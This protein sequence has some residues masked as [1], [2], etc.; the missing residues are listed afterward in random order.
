MNKPHSKRRLLPF[1]LIIPL[2]VISSMAYLKTKKEA[3]PPEIHGIYFSQAE[4]I[5][6]FELTKAN[7]ENFN[8]QD[9]KGHWTLMFF[10]FT[11]CPDVC[12]TTLAMLDNVIHELDNVPNLIKPNVVFVS[13]DPERDNL[14]QLDKYV[15]FFNKDFTAATGTPN[16][17]HQLSRQLGIIYDKV[18]MSDEDPDNY[19][20][21]HS[22]SITLINPQGGIQAIFTAPHDAEALKE[23]IVR[24]YQAY[25]RS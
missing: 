24:V 5:M 4:F 21:E 9:L 19:I 1:L 18:Y 7:S 15:S 3:Q 12:P 8:D 25:G 20:M 2:L 22:T 13:V 14:A 17:L 6:P 16:Q 10:G 23:D 11:Y